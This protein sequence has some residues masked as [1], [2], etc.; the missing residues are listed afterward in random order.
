MDIRSHVLGS[1]FFTRT[2]LIS[3]W[4]SFAIRKPDKDHMFRNGGN[5]LV[6]PAHLSSGFLRNYWEIHLSYRNH[7]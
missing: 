6:C 2:I 7:F 4:N 3:L 5:R 1:I